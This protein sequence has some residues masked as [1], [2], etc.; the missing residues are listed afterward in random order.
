MVTVVQSIYGG[1]DDRTDWL[2]QTTRHEHIHVNEPRPHLHPRMAAK[3]AKCQPWRYADDTVY[4]WVDGSIVPTDNLFLEH[5]LDVSRGPLSQY[6]HPHRDCIETEARV[7]AGMPK[8]Q[9]QPVIRQAA[10]YMQAGHPKRWGLWATGIIVYRPGRL[11]PLHELGAAR[12]AE[13]SAWTVQDQISQPYL[14]HRFGLRPHTIPG[15]IFHME[16]ATI[17]AHNDA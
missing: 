9:G 8:Y 16:H 7:S 5:L 10:S 13:M 11:Y 3:V 2:I 12:L 4:I 15:D 14:L 6:R 1:Y 17:R